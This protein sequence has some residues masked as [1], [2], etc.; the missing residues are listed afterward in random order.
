MKE[1]KKGTVCGIE[2]GT[3]FKNKIMSMGI[4]E[5]REITKLSHFALRGPVAVKI[6]RSILAL[7]HGMASRITVEVK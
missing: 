3:A 1:N 4:Y 2:G 5:G 6:G 7:G